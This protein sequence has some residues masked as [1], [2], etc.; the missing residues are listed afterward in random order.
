MIPRAKIVEACRIIKDLIR[1]SQSN[2]AHETVIFATSILRKAKNRDVFLKAVKKACGQDIDVISGL[3]ECAC[4][5][6]AARYFSTI[7]TGPILLVDIGGGSTEFVLFDKERTYLRKSYSFG[8]AYIKG[9]YGI[10]AVEEVPAKAL[11]RFFHAK[12]RLFLKAMVQYTLENIIV[13]S[14]VAK[15]MAGLKYGGTVNAA[16]GQKKKIYL[17]DIVM[18]QQALATDA[19]MV[20]LDHER[21]ILVQIGTYF[22]AE[23]LRMTNKRFFSVAPHSVRE[24]YLLHYLHL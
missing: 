24:G 3:G 21:K 13:T 15:I 10:N 14:S 5:E 7:K 16:D 11:E 4:L 22:F 12:I 20:A 9:K 18:L 23:L 6:K 19:K 1:F 2:N 17:R 8:L